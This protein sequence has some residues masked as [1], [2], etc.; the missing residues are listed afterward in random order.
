M[1]IDVPAQRLEIGD[2][3]LLRLPGADA[4]VEAK[5]V[6]ALSERPPASAPRC[7]WQKAK[8]SSRNGLWA[9]SSRSFAVL[10]GGCSRRSK[11]RT[12]RAPAGALAASVSAVL[13][14]I[15]SPID[16]VRVHGS[17]GD[18]RRGQ[19]DGCAADHGGAEYASCCERQLT[20]TQFV[21]G[22]LSF[23]ASLLY[24]L[25]LGVRLLRHGGRGEPLGV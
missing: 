18:R 1:A 12:I 14:P 17:G 4:T 25:T 5:L 22:G 23:H 19:G 6:R 11:R 3:V 24:M 8:I 13:A 20:R 21:D 15:H 9:N 2:V 10:D 7:E 16:A